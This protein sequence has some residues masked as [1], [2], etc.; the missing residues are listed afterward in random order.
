M[1]GAE[2]PTP[3]QPQ[4]TR[5]G[6]DATPHRRRICQG[7]SAITASSPRPP[8]TLPRPCCPSHHP[9]VSLAAC[10]CACNRSAIAVR[11]RQLLPLLTS[12]WLDACVCI[13][14]QSRC[15]TNEGVVIDKRRGAGRWRTF[16][17][18]YVSFNRRYANMPHPSTCFHS[19]RYWILDSVLLRW[20]TLGYFVALDLFFG[21]G[22]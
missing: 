4:R 17:L 18:I 6:P 19:T 13:R 22:D 12:E 8:P 11:E 5:P 1:L 10:P 21:P 16:F 2:Q 20:L 15:I 3:T 9:A 7:R 14:W